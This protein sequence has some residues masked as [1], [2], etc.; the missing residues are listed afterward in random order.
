MRG[1][2]AALALVAG[3]VHPRG[4]GVAGDG[5]GLA[6]T[7]HAD[8]AT[9]AGRGFVDDRRML[10]VPADGWVELDDVAV[11]ADL[12]S[13]L[14]SS[15]TAPGS[16]RTGECRPS[17]GARGLADLGATIGRPV[18]A[19]LAA[20]APVRGTLAAVGPTETLVKDDALGVV[21]ASDLNA[22][23]DS[24]A[25]DAPAIGA[26]VRGTTAGGD[27]VIG[28]VVSVRPATLTIAVDG[29]RVR[30]LPVG[31]LVRLDV[32]G[33]GG[34]LRCRVRSSH[35]GA[36]LVRLAYASPGFA[37]SAHYRATVPADGAATSVPLATRYTVVAPGLPAAR[38]A[39][40]RLIAGLPDDAVTPVEAWA[41]AV[42][43]GGGPVVVS[44]PTVTR[45]ARVG[46][47]YRGALASPD[48]VPSGEYWHNASHGLVWRELAL[49]PAPSDVAGPIDV[50]PDGQPARAVRAALPAPALDPPAAARLPLGASATLVGFRQKRELVRDARHIVD[51]ILY[52][53]INHGDAPAEVTIEEELRYPTDATVRFER[54]DGAG[55]L[56]RDRWRR[57]VTVP[58]DG[59]ARGALVLQYRTPP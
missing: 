13:V 16:L 45:E 20:G 36:Q 55:T 28:P 41:G 51:E 38:P 5:P 43:L 50:V 2:A 32:D 12:D 57:V 25:I 8:R 39:T 9:G 31:G 1:P 56:R 4:G 19:T 27:Q 54:P 35:P 26:T 40:V 58:P 17:G 29:G 59:V 33:D 46:W 53:V 15:L 44:G 22:P 23:D 11:D 34:G 14:L 18:T 6:V 42:T 7:I 24:G 52:S 21:A 3:C 47:V 37:W 30:E 48:E 49:A 10:A